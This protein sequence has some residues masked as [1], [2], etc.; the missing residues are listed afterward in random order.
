MHFYD[1]HVK[2]YIFYYYVVL[3]LL[4][5]DSITVQ[6][7]NSAEMIEIYQFIQYDP[8]LYYFSIPYGDLTSNDFRLDATEVG[9]DWRYPFSPWEYW[10]EG[11][12][13]PC[14]FGPHFCI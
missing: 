6:Y 14:W 9:E 12:Y 3:N 11:Y 1:L 10:H 7:S 4:V 5:F 13:R 8:E 2:I